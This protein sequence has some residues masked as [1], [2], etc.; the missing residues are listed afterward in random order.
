[1]VQNSV[2]G[3]A[4]PRN[5][6]REHFLADYYGKCNKNAIFYDFWQKSARFDS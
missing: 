6:D 2:G 3:G 1:L 5:V 4:L